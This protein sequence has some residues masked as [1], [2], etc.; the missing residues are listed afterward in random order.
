M[1]YFQR[2]LYGLPSARVTLRRTS[3]LPRVPRSAAL[4][5]PLSRLSL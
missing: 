1:R 3:R 5:S 4:T 2:R